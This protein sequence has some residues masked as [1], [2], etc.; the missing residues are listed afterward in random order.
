MT[1]NEAV[2]DPRGRKEKM[3]GPGAIYAIYGKGTVPPSV[4]CTPVRNSRVLRPP[5]SSIQILTSP[6]LR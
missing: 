4:P 1:Q 6:D 3:P 2:R 5:V